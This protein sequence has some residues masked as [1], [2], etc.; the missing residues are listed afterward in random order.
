MKSST[1]FLVGAFATSA[2]AFPALQWENVQARQTSGNQGG[3]HIPCTPIQPA[4]DAQSQYVST[5]GQYE[6]VAPGPTD[7]RG[8][9]PG[10]NAAA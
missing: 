3:A 4:F 7:A 8:P 1:S 6:W 5:S 9:C 10:L 2:S